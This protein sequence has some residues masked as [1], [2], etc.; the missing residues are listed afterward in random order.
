[1]D[2]FH[3]E[4]GAIPAH[5]CHEESVPMLQDH[6]NGKNGTSKAFLVHDSMAC[7]AN[8]TLAL[9]DIASTTPGL[10][11]DPGIK[12]KTSNTKNSLPNAMDYKPSKLTTP[13]SPEYRSLSPFNLEDPVTSRAQSS[14]KI[15]ARSSEGETDC[16]LRSGELD[17]KEPL[18]HGILASS[19]SNNR[20]QVSTTIP[21]VAS[22]ESNQPLHSST[23]SPPVKN[24]MVS[25]TSR[26]PED[27]DK[28]KKKT[29]EELAKEWQAGQANQAGQ[30]SQESGQK[31]AVSSKQLIESG[32]DEESEMLIRHSTY[33]SSCSAV[34]GMTSE[35]YKLRK[36]L[37]AR[38][39]LHEDDVNRA[40]NYGGQPLVKLARD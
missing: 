3:V 16:L 25:E 7:I 29:L 33:Y 1:M 38:L 39:H 26:S 6:S 9:G 15:A 19:L 14:T 21:S 34:S 20:D 23:S 40:R 32:E 2:L 17:Q 37:K 24:A 13:R 10:V 27:Q 35:E 8:I 18:K 4:T 12:N 11:K 5:S 30:A 31:E 36:K 22:I 28:G